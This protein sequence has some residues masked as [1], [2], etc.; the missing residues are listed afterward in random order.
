MSRYSTRIGNREYTATIYAYP[1][2]P[3]C[4]GHELPE[5]EITVKASVSAYVPAKFSGHP[6]TWAPAEGGEVEILSATANGA[7]WELSADELDKA[8][9]AI[10]DKAREDDD[11]GCERD[12]DDFEPYEDEAW[13]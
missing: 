8:E 1:I 3:E 12:A 2:G 13:S 10:I 6:D 9:E 4:E 7:A 5:V 11:D